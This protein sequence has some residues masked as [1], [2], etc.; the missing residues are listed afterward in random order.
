MDIM[1]IDV[2][3]VI[4]DFTDF[5]NKSGPFSKTKEYLC[6]AAEETEVLKLV[7]SIL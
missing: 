2:R 6:V 5:K 1:E 7:D 4:S 3:T